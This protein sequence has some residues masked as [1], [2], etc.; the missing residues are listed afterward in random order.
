MAES[1]VK[2][3]QSAP[4][5]QVELMTENKRLADIPISNGLFFTL[6]L[7]PVLLCL[8]LGLAHASFVLSATTVLIL[9]AADFWLTKNHFGLGLVGLRWSCDKRETPEFPFLVCYSRPFPFVASTLDSNIFWL[10]L[11][12][13]AILDIVLSLVF[14]VESPKWFVVSLV[15]LSLN[16]MNFYGFMRCHAVSKTQADNAARTLLLD[17]SVTMFQAANEAKENE[18]TTDESEIEQENQESLDDQKDPTDEEMEIE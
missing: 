12:C 1:E 16:A 15:L 8:I 3:V 6:R 14:M 17:T 11:L 4:E 9:A 10:G 18:P 2:T 5:D 13:A 7:G